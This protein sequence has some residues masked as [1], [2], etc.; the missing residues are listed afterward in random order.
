MRLMRTDFDPA[1]LPPQ[2]FRRIH[3]F[4][5]PDRS[6]EFNTSG[7]LPTFMQRAQQSLIERD[8]PEQVCQQLYE[9]CR[10]PNTD[11]EAKWYS[12]LWIRR[13]W[14]VGLEYGRPY[15]MDWVVCSAVCALRVFSRYPFQQSS[16]YIQIVFGLGARR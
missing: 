6:H 14:N 9:D 4:R 1:E 16:P 15:D 7:E 12:G 11:R 13:C 3:N 10:K 8:I 2:Q 5:S